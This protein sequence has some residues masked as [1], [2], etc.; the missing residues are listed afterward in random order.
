MH[1]RG[2]L[3]RVLLIAFCIGVLVATSGVGVDW[4][5]HG[6]RRHLLPSDA[7]QGFVAALISGLALAGHERHHRHLLFRMQAIEDVNHHVRNALTAITYS[8]AIKDDPALAKVIADANQRVD[9]VLR[10]VL[11]KH[12]LASDDDAPLPNQWPKGRAMSA[13]K[14]DAAPTEVN[15][16]G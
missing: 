14:D 4:L 12:V 10:E 3:W 13:P 5:L 7:L 8:A 15:S 9:W 1:R 2:Y 11:S 6:S 16:S